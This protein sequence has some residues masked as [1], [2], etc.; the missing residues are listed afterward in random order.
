[1]YGQPRK[2]SR[3]QEIVDE[4]LKTNSPETIRTHI[5]FRVRDYIKYVEEHNISSPEEVPD[6][7]IASFMEPLNG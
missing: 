7:I 1:M 4:Y 3:H 6:E 2:F 5:P